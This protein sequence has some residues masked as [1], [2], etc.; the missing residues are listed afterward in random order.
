MHQ[1]FEDSFHGE[2]QITKSS[3]EHSDAGKLLKNP[4]ISYIAHV[5][6]T[7]LPN[8]EVVTPASII[9]EPCA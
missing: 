6:K 3:L 5:V 7:M 8:S 2:A 1:E 9:E 4:T